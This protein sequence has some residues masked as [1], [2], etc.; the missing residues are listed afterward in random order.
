VSS[1]ARRSVPRVDDQSGLCSLYTSPL[2]LGR[3]GWPS[4]AADQNNW[5]RSTKLLSRWRV[6]MEQSA[7]GNKD[8]ITDTLAG[9]KLK[10]FFAVTTCQCSCHNFYYNTAWNINSVTELNWTELISI[11][12]LVNFLQYSDAAGWAKKWLLLWRQES[13]VLH[14]VQSAKTEVF[15]IGYNDCHSR[16]CWRVLNVNIGPTL[17]NTVPLMVSQHSCQCINVCIPTDWLPGRIQDLPK[18]GGPWRVQSMSL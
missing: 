6:S 10:C 12:L 5:L 9:W 4:C 2:A 7:A 18:R 11:L 14:A 13:I 16:Q 8:D 15:H 17:C 1:P 3:S